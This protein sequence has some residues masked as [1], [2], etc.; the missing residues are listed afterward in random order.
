MLLEDVD[1]EDEAAEGYVGCA[2]GAAKARRG[3]SE[4][5][6]EAARG[7]GGGGGGG[8]GRVVREAEG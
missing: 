1:G 5:R 7:D 4:E 6:E 2:R 8:E 3:C